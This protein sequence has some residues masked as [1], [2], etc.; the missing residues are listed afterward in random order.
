MVFK[1]YVKLYRTKVFHRSKSVKHL[2]LSVN[3]ALSIDEL[4]I[5]VYG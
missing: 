3:P 1:V 4:S 5:F 2:A